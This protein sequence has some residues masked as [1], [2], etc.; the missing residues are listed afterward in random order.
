[1]ARVRKTVD[2]G[3]REAPD[4]LLEETAVED[5]VLL[6]PADH[7][8]PIQEA[9]KTLLY[10][11][12]Y[13]VGTVAGDERDVLHEAERRDAVRPRVIGRAIGRADLRAHGPAP[14]AQIRGPEREGVHSADEEGAQARVAAE[15][16]LPREQHPL[17]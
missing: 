9:L 12:D 14:A 10:F 5:E 17:R 15:L 3:L 6:A 13:G 16:E 4:P 2:F 8:R 1:M 11:L 7:H